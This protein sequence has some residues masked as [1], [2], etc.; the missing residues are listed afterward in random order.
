MANVIFTGPTPMGGPAP[1]NNPF[2]DF[3]QAAESIAK[4]LV[5]Q[6][7]R[8]T[9]AEIADLIK[10]GDYEGAI[11]ASLNSP[12]PGKYADLVQTALGLQKT[13]AD[14][15]ATE[16]DTA[17][18]KQATEIEAAPKLHNAPLGST[19][20]SQ[21]PLTGKT[22]V[23]QTG[24]TAKERDAQRLGALVSNVDA[25]IRANPPEK[26]GDP[27]LDGLQYMYERNVILSDVYTAAGETD[28]AS[29]A[30]DDA[31]AALTAIEGAQKGRADVNRWLPIAEGDNVVGVIDLRQPN[32]GEAIQREI[33]AGRQPVQRPAIQRTTTRTAAQTG[34][35]TADITQTASSLARTAQAIR[36]AQNTPE[37]AFGWLGD[38]A[39]KVTGAVEPALV[40]LNETFGRRF[41]NGATKFLTG[42][43]REDIIRLQ[44]EVRTV[45]APLARE[46]TAEQGS[47][48]SDFE[49]DWARQTARFVSGQA[50]K[51]DTIQGLKYALVLQ[52]IRLD[53]LSFQ[54]NGAFAFDMT[55]EQN[56][57]D[58]AVN[59]VHSTGASTDEIFNDYIPA[60][61]EHQ[62]A[63]SS[64]GRA[65]I[66][67]QTR[68][69]EELGYVG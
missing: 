9:R 31:R 46:Y 32:A 1:P 52:M 67:L 41:V 68:T 43:K 60:L 58:L 40:H 13:Q 54:R 49:F 11:A 63:L 42:A 7:D 62:A 24:T 38:T 66:P 34:E 36:T 53:R 37:G 15:E 35:L 48:F 26:T 28:A 6:R 64:Y 30:Q 18:T 59:L 22:S 10:K 16:A 2:Q 8:R 65:G 3:P 56:I 17:R 61:I 69:A 4:G 25:S 50:T 12:D 33:A 51:S 23:V 29:R 20:L 27:I 21:E 44:T 5:A 57:K 45:F 55:N 14:I 47:R 39:L 19:V